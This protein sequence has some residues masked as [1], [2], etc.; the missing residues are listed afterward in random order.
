LLPLDAD[1]IQQDVAAVAQQL[2]VVHAGEPRFEETAD[3]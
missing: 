1:L 2:L 3:Y